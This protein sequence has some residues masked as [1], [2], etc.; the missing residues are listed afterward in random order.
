MQQGSSDITTNPYR[1]TVEK[2]ANGTV[3][4]RLIGGNP[5]TRADA[6]RR[7]VQFSPSSTYFWKFTWGQGTARLR[8]SQDDESGPV[9]FDNTQSYGGT[10]R[11]NPHT[12]HLGAPPGR[13]GVVDASV[14]GAIIRSVWISSRPRPD[15]M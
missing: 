14:P 13:G 10:Y 8:I 5:D 3:S 9:L 1:A 11:P 4:F 15:G 7:I 6:E 2:R 12:A